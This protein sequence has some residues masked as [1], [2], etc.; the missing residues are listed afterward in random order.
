MR[1]Y[2][3]P[4]KLETFDATL[5]KWSGDLVDLSLFNL[6]KNAKDK[7]KRLQQL[8]QINDST[9]KE[10]GSL[11]VTV[12]D[13]QLSDPHFEGFSS[14]A[15][16]TVDNLPQLASEP[17]ASINDDGVLETTMDPSGTAIPIAIGDDMLV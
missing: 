9:L 5:D 16:T 7:L 3:N 11:G 4:E 6:W 17:S 14:S 13:F 1:I 10:V 8:N 12:D 2:T 15:I